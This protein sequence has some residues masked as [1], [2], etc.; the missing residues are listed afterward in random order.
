MAQVVIRNIDDAAMRRLKVAPDLVLAEAANTLWK[1]ASRRELSDAEAERA[2]AVLSAS[3]LAFHPTP[4]LLPRAL[5]LARL[6]GR[7][8][9]DC[10]YLALA[11]RERARMVTAD[12]RLLA[13]AGSSRLRA[14]VVDLRR[15]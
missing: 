5:R 7:P 3:G 6:L 14:R 10:V 15:F 13:R 1:K 9:Y 4:P 11:E 8:V 12:T 2:F